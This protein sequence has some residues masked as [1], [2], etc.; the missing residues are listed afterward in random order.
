MQAG[1]SRP[2]R[3]T[4]VEEQTYPAMLEEPSLVCGRIKRRLGTIYADFFA[5]TLDWALDCA[6]GQEQQRRALRDGD[7]PQL[8]V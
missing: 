2:T 8:G 4:A 1:S 6:T 3:L 5:K 7:A